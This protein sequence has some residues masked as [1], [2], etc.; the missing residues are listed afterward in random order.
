MVIIVFLVC[1]AASTI[2]GI[3]GI[4]GGVVIKPVLDSL[5]LM[6]VSTISFLSACTVL[7]MAFVSVYR[8]RKQL[9]QG[10]LSGT[11]LAIGAALGGIAGKMLFDLLKAKLDQDARLLLIQS[12]VLGVLVLGTLMYT[13]NK[14]RIRTRTVEGKY[15]TVAVGFTLG[16]LS[17]FLGIG[18]GP[19]NLVVLHYFF[20]MET[21]K[22]TRNSLYIVLLSQLANLAQTFLAAKVPEFQ[23]SML[24]VMASGG[25][26]GG[27][28]GSFAHKRLSA[29]Q[30][31]RL[32]LGLLVVILCICVYNAFCAIQRF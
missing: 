32:F 5:H 12:V 31:D 17:S 11:L 2:G 26:L 6:S 18:G 13:L 8:S 30:T 22:A 14:S 20:S 24:L 28:F 25:V 10:G 3:C 7:S 16:V 21:K 4:G 19:F 23:V 15:A 1:V 9:L 29:E 27:L